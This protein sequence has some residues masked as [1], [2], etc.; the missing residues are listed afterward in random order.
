MNGDK[1]TGRPKITGTGEVEGPASTLLRM[2]A[3]TPAADA[4]DAVASARFDVLQTTVGEWTPAMC[5]DRAQTL[6]DAEVRLGTGGDMEGI[7]RQ[8]AG[9]MLIALERLAME[10]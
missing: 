10:G 5:L 2:F 7:A 8:V 1:R 3:G 4:L 9:L 6:I